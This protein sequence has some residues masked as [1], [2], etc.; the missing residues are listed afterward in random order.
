MNQ[1]IPEKIHIIGSVGSGKTTL[2]RKLS[3]QL[4]IPY[5]EL[6]NVVWKR[7]GTGDI[8]RTP[9]ERDNYLKDIVNLDK[10]VIEGVHH[11]WI[12]PCLQNADVILFLDTKLS[13]RRFRIIKRF[14]MQKLGLETANYKP[15][16]RIL[17]DLYK[18]N[19]VFEYHSKPEILKMLRPYDN[20]LILFKSDIEIINY[21]KTANVI[22]RK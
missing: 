10:W 3:T 6:D 5:Y 14:F 15:T 21:F 20:K 2:A 22:A 18:Y 13:I 1:K 11:K 17:K 7:F 8:K 12:V 9:K 16:L 4:Q 19:T